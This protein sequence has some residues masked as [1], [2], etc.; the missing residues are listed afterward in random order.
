MLNIRHRG[1]C[2]GQS[3][4]FLTDAAVHLTNVSRVTLRNITVQRTGSYAVWFDVASRDSQL[5]HSTLVDLGAGGVRVGPASGG[6]PPPGAE[7]VRVVITDNVIEDGGH[8]I[9]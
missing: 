1:T 6:V 7:A 5:E 8:V 9:K 4:D 3:A 2:D